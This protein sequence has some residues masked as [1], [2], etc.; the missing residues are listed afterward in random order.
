MFDHCEKKKKKNDSLKQ[1]D[2]STFGQSPV[3]SKL[4]MSSERVKKKEEKSK[5]I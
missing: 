4:K 5:R 1:I 3:S 2:L